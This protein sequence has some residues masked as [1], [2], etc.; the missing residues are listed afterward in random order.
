VDTYWDLLNQWINQCTTNFQLTTIGYMMGLRHWQLLLAG[1]YR[2]GFSSRKRT[3]KLWCVPLHW[4]KLS[5]LHLKRIGCRITSMPKPKRRNGT[6]RSF[7]TMMLAC[8]C[9][10]QCWYLD[11]LES[12]L[13]W[14]M[15]RGKQTVYFPVREI[16]TRLLVQK[17]MSADILL[18]L[19]A[20]C[21]RQMLSNTTPLVSAIIFLQKLL[22]K[23]IKIAWIT[24]QF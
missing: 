14:L 24:F 5:K 9:W 11:W 7:S 15:R 17:N 8:A 4:T 12:I 21:F 20:E 23:H 3:V 1:V 10:Q 2:L 18:S 13:Q 19:N 6:S 22:Q 16:V